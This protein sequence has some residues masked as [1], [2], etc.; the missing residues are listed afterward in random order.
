MKEVN[1]TKY[2]IRGASPP[3]VFVPRK[4]A[5]VYSPARA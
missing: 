1:L 2:S 5:S 3:P 4:Q